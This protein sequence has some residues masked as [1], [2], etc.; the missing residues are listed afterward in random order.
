[1]R[2]KRLQRK[3]YCTQKSEIDDLDN[4]TLVLRRLMATPTFVIQADVRQN[5]LVVFLLIFSIAYRAV[6]LEAGHYCS[7]S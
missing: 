1:V 6:D 7:G 2:P 5:V 4:Q 3:G